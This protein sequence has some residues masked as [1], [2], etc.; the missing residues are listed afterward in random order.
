M[1][2][3][4]VYILL[5]EDG[6]TTDTYEAVYILMNNSLNIWQKISI[7]RFPDSMSWSKTPPT[8][9]FIT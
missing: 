2:M 1:K 5:V 4:N 6:H 7:K 3:K 9:N 8:T